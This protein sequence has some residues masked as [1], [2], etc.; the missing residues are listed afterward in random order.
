MEVPGPGTESRPLLWPMLQ[1]QQ[2]RILKPLHWARAWTHASPGIRAIAVG[3]LTQLHHIGNS[4]NFKWRMIYR[5]IE[6]LCCIPE[7]KIVNQL[8]MLFNN[9]FESYSQ[10][11]SRVHKTPHTFRAWLCLGF[12]VPLSFSRALDSLPPQV[13]GIACF[14][15]FFFFFPRSF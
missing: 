5:N 3:F 13:L 10:D 12:F 9:N 4:T 8:H 1:L 6:S 15:F 14:F 2:H 7:T 11:S